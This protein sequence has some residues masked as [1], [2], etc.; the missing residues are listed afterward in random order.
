MIGV[1]GGLALTGMRPIVALVRAVPRRA[2]VRAGQARSGP[3]GRRRGAGEHGRVVRRRRARGGRTR[4]PRTWR[5][6]TRCPAGRSTSP[7]IPTRSSASCARAAA[8]DDNVYVRL[9]EEVNAAPV[10]G[11]GL[12]VR[13]LAA[14]RRRRSSSRSGRRSTRCWPRPPISTSSVAY[15]RPSVRSTARAPRG[16][17]RGTD[18]VLVE[19]Y[20]A[21]TSAA[22][23]AAALADRPHRLLALGVANGRCAATA[24]GP[25]HRALHGLDAAGIRASIAAFLRCSPHPGWGSYPSPLAGDDIGLTRT[26]LCR[27][28]DEYCRRGRRP[29]SPVPQRMI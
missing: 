18:V 26:R 5:C 16:A 8:G 15:L 1:A 25:E 10:E 13:A 12:V 22:E 19:P 17:L 3:P 27:F 11:D 28:C 14:V 9:S 24:A 21:G 2:A 6:S 7:A 20:L 4:R 23:V 29:A